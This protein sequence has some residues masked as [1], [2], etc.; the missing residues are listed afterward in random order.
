MPI[1]PS[2]LGPVLECP[3]CH[4]TSPRPPRHRCP[5]CGRS[6]L[7]DVTEPDTERLDALDARAAATE[8]ILVVVGGLLLAGSLLATLLAFFKLPDSPLR[9]FYRYIMVAAA[10]T[11]GFVL[12]RYLSGDSVKLLAPLAGLAW[13]VLAIWIWFA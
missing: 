1:N 10:L 11:A 8:R 12:H 7:V 4:H 9:P 13:F 2:N 6:P 3:H 5:N